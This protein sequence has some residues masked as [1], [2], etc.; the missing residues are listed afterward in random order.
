MKKIPWWSILILFVGYAWWCVPYWHCRQCQCC[1]GQTPP[2]AQSSGVPLFKWSAAQPDSDPNF[3]SWKKALL[4]K[5]GQGDT[6]T[7]TGLYRSAESFAGKDGNLGLSRASAIK[8]LLM[9]EIPDSRIHLAAKTVSD[10]W[11]ATGA[12]RECAEFSWTKMMLKKEAGAIIESNNAVTFLFPF[13]S[14]EKDSDPSVD[15]YLKKLVEQHKNSPA[16]FSVTGHTD[17]VGDAEKNK[18]L[19]LGRANSIAKILIANGIDP[20]RIKIDSK[21]ETEPITDNNSDDGRHQNRRVVL[22][23]IH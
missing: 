11:S 15:A 19:G 17:D 21:G 2:A 20:G 1:D 10:N 9:P 18:A 4:S 8:A 23:I 13:N 14:T 22:T 5:G 16:T 3:A 6:L 7:I 12:A